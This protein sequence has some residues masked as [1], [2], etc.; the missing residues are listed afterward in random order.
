[1]LRD[2]CEETLATGFASVNRRLEQIEAWLTA[3]ERR[4]KRGRDMRDLKAQLRS[5]SV[6][7]LTPAL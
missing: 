3:R 1:M 5:T 2:M 4:L 7:E 6:R